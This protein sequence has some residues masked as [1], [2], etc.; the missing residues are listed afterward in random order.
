MKILSRSFDI[1][2]SGSLDKYCHAHLLE[3]KH[4]WKNP[5]S[6]HS[7]KDITGLLDEINTVLNTKMAPDNDDLL[8]P[9][10]GGDPAPQLDQ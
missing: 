6:L 7:K 9:M 3:E 2:N 1:W 10:I 5:K 4:P 8:I